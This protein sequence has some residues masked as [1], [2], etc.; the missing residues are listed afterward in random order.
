MS[1]HTINGRSPHVELA[2]AAI[3]AYVERGEKVAVTP[4]GVLSSEGSGAAG[5]ALDF[6]ELLAERAG[7]FV[8][9]KKHGALRGCIGTI[10]PV[11]DSLAGEIVE[12]AISACSRD[13]RFDPVAPGELGDLTVSVDV[14]M[15]PEPLGSPAELDVVR[16][17]VIVSR[18][19][20][21]GL[22]LPNLEGVDS[23]EEQL[24]IALSKAGIRPSEQ[25]SME[26]FEVVRHERGGHMGENAR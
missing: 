7:A 5:Q 21:R 2:K 14:L 11:M 10:S 12:N 22:L 15:A 25:Y 16:Y 26:R 13:P 19:Y 23:V 24:R 3:R 6:S 8:S 4:G 18:G 9:I 20:R 1:D 17:G